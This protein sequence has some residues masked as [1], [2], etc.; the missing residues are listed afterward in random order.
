MGYNK[1]KIRNKNLDE[2]GIRL[3]PTPIGSSQYHVLP[4]VRQEFVLEPHILAPTA[5]DTPFAEAAEISTENDFQPKKRDISKRWKRSKRSKNIA[6]GIIMFIVTSLVILPYLLGIFSQRLDFVPFEYTPVQFNAIGNIVQAFRVSAALG[7]QG[8][9]VNAIWI[10]CVSDMILLV[11]IFALVI[12]LIKSVAAIVGAVKPVRFN[13]G[14]ILYLLSVLA[15]FVAAL[16][17][18][19]EIGVDKIDFVQDVIYGF[20]TSELFSLLVF[21]IGNVIVCAVCTVVNPD[22]SGYLS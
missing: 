22:K 6:V 17:G 7:W 1:N 15:I 19:P 4:S 18:A 13:G 21:A 3:A 20:R 5:P 14:A 10:Y 9:L 2:A 8:E 16:V 12:N 11:G